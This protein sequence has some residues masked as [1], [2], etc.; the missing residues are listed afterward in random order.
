V[1]KVPSIFSNPHNLGM[2]RD[3]TNEL[4]MNSIY[5]RCIFIDVVERFFIVLPFSSKRGFKHMTGS[6]TFATACFA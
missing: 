1:A 4:E 2:E 5:I 3:I 6:N